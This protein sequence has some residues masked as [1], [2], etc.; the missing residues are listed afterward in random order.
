MRS[1]SPDVGPPT[2]IIKYSLDPEF[3]FLR[4]SLNNMLVCIGKSGEDERFEGKL[5][6]PYLIRSGLDL[7]YLGRAWRDVDLENKGFLDKKQAIQLLVR[8]AEAQGKEGEPPIF[9]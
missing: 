4:P 9:R 2:P 7:A 1:S 5:L 8:I 3:E 6:R